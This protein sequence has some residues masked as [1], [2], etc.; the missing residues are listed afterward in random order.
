MILQVTWLYVL[1]QE[2]KGPIPSPA[3]PPALIMSSSSSLFALSLY[4]PWIILNAEYPDSP[5][6][7]S[8]DR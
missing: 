1:V 8:W 3:R 5:T 6:K 7:L 4:E 2:T